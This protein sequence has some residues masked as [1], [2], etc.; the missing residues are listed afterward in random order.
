MT[1]H[2]K[3]V[4]S[5]SI[6]SR[7]ALKIKLNKYLIINDFTTKFFCFGSCFATSISN[8]LKALGFNAYYDYNFSNN[9]SIKAIRHL[10]ESLKSGTTQLIKFPN[11]S[12]VMSHFHT[13]V[14][15]KGVG[16]ESRIIERI[17]LINQRALE[18]ILRSDIFV[19]TLGNATYLEHKKTGKAITSAMG[20]DSSEY[21]IKRQSVNDICEDLSAVY[22]L[23][24]DFKNDLKLIITISPQRYSWN[25]ENDEYSGMDSAVYSN[26]EKAKLRCAIDQFL[27]GNDVSE[28]SYYPS[29]DIAID[30][31]R[32]CETISMN[33]SDFLHVSDPK[34]PNY[35]IN[36]FLLSHCSPELIDCLEFCRN[37]MGAK[38]CAD[39]ECKEYDEVVEDVRGVLST[40]K[41]Y[42]AHLKCDSFVNSAWI[43][44]SQ[45]GLAELYTQYFPAKGKEGVFNRVN[46]LIDSSHK[47]AV[48]GIGEHTDFL[49]KN[50]NILQCKQCVFSDKRYLSVPTYYSFPVVNPKE[51][52]SFDIDF[53]IISSEAFENEI[54]DS[55][56]STGIPQSKL[57]RLYS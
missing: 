21:I 41:N 13:R 56:K 52:N 29:Y 12:K 38:F 31:L 47:I 26:L 4:V 33:N 39:I 10:L 7:S 20:L 40:L 14:I 49:L 43:K 24:K 57:I 55:L 27:T 22:S 51:L 44:L 54:Y 17:R 42:H 35:I 53:V 48:Y 45:N 19:M 18:E 30:E 37:K 16:A 8:V 46:T 36:R 23:L 9:Y 11:S 2:D 34:T 15:E 1:N 50:T 28:A 5:G 3:I 32:H 6:H 25:F